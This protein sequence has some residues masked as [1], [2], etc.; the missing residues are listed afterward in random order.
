[1]TLEPYTV[2]TLYFGSVASAEVAAFVKTILSFSENLLGV[3]VN[4]SSIS[5]VD[6]GVQWLKLLIKNWTVIR[7]ETKT[8]T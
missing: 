6:F 8:W 2:V 5:S 7:K 4:L 3:I 1:M